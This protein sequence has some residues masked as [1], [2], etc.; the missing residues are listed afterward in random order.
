MGSRRM[1][2]VGYEVWATKEPP[3]KNTA[4]IHGAK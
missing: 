3:V 4:E 2:A 1:N